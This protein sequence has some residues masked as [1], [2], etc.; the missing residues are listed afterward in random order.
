MQTAS[1]AKNVYDNIVYY[2]NHLMKKEG[3]NNW[4]NYWVV[5]KGKWLLFYQPVEQKSRPTKLVKTIEL[6][7]GSKFSMVPRSKRRFPFSL[8]NGHGNYYFKCETELQRYT[9]IVCALLA[10]TGQAPKP[11]PKTIPKDFTEVA[12][13]PKMA[14]YEKKIEHSNK[15][16]ECK[17]SGQKDKLVSKHRIRYAQRLEAKAKNYLSKS[18]DD[19]HR[20]DSDDDEDYED[21]RPHSARVPG[22]RDVY[23]KDFVYGNERA[24]YSELRRTS[25]QSSSSLEIHAQ[26][27]SPVNNKATSNFHEVSETPVMSILEIENDEYGTV[28]VIPPDEILPNMVME[29]RR[30]PA[31]L[32]ARSNKE[33]SNGGRSSHLMTHSHS[34]SDLGKTNLAISIDDEIVNRDSRPLS[35]TNR[36]RT[37]LSGLPSPRLN[38]KKN[39]TGKLLSNESNVPRNDP[40]KRTHSRSPVPKGRYSRYNATASDA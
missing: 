5:I 32:S 17:K 9:W 2:Q 25:S 13:D 26:V 7:N 6:P 21:R 29:E 27:H 23:T 20:Q 39:H 12:V 28:H 37:G 34:T 16:L 8:C 38:S 36:T 24:R 19:I 18:D 40:A 10:S 35:T 30:R 4:V 31:P 1:A 33:N 22:Q 11:V 14:K 15:K 3:L